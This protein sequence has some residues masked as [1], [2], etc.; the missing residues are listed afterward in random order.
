MLGHNAGSIEPS[1][2]TSPNVETAMLESTGQLP[3][4]AEVQSLPIMKVEVGTCE[5]RKVLQ[6]VS[7]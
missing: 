1:Q 4:A 5:G 6:R 7:L 3:P 2:V